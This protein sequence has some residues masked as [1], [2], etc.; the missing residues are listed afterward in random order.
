MCNNTKQKIAAS[1]RQMMS[2]RPFD[3]ITVKNLMD[4]TSMQRQ[5][6]YYHFQDTRDVLMWICQEELFTPLAESDLDFSEWVMLALRLLDAD[7]PFFRRAV[8]AAQADFLRELDRQAVRPRI[9][10]LLYGSG[11]QLDENRTFVVEVISNAVTDFFLR[12]ANSLSSPD[13]SDTRQK[14]QFLLSELKSGW[15]APD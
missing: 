4:A 14:L 3:K 9:S 2:R 10:A 12:F 6:F 13:L 11:R 5:S 8:C 7:R 15:N 1:L